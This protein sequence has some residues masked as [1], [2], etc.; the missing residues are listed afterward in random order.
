LLYAG[1]NFIGTFTLPN[2]MRN[3]TS[4]SPNRI[5]SILNRK[6][7]RQHSPFSRALLDAKDLAIYLYRQGTDLIRNSFEINFEYNARTDWRTIGRKDKRAML[8]DVTTAALSLLGLP[9]P[10]RPPECD[11]CLQQEPEGPSGWAYKTQT[12]PPC[13]CPEIR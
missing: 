2:S 12:S 7:T 8:T 13:N 11:C 5:S 3:L 4:I 6:A 9:V 10:I 1:R